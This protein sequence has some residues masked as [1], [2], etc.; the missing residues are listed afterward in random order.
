MR[1]GNV[2]ITVVVPC[3]N[4]GRF[5][6]QA[7]A[8]AEQSVACEM[9][10]LVLNDGST[11]G[12]LD[13]M[14]RHQATDAR[15][16][17][18]D[19]PNEGYGATMN[20][21]IAE[22]RGT[23]VAV[24]EP[25]DWVVSRAYDNLFALACT[26]GNPDV[27]K[28]SYW[29]VMSCDGTDGTKAHGYLYGR[30]GRT[31]Q[32]ILLED[33]PQLIQY[34]P[35]IWSALYAREFLLREGIRFVEAPGAGWVDNP[36]CVETLAAADSIVYTDD[37]YYCYRE[38]LASA[39]SATVSARLMIDR[40]NDRQGVL[41]RRGITNIGIVRANAVVALRY[42]GSMLETDAL[43]DPELYARARRMLQRLNA[44]M[45]RSIDCI[46]PHV[47][48]KALRIMGSD[49]SA[50]PRAPYAAHLA[51]EAWWALRYNGPTFLAHNLALAKKR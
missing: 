27:V 49:L 40:W 10:I 4:E 29:R 3:Y 39:S 47:V 24:L 35:S 44:H 18:I 38:D 19:K 45:V 37:A 34:H 43:D 28:G 9:E 26:H 50:P 51:H 48:E 5:L 16:R 12:S 14:L 1:G 13:I 25:D 23:Y 36:F 2:D 22:A 11:D 20:R 6:D 15:V 7:L 46:H 17:V 21:G 32:R 42:L 31:N 41:D 33:E 30:V 8:S